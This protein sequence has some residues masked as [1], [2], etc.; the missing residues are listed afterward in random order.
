MKEWT[1]LLSVQEQGNF[2]D[3][4]EEYYDK[5][6]DKYLDIVNNKWTDMTENK[7]PGFSPPPPEWF[8]DQISYEW[9]ARDIQ[10]NNHLNKKQCPACANKD[11][12]FKKIRSFATVIIFQSW[13]FIPKQ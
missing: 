12:Y 4:L 8:I 13:G 9:A 10:L 3:Y 11:T 2:G 7:L 1:S 6:K 5:N